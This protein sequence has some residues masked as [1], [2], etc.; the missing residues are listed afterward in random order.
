MADVAV[1]VIEDSKREKSDN[2]GEIFFSSFAQ[3]KISPLLCEEL[4][5]EGGIVSHLRAGS[6]NEENLHKA[7][8][9]SAT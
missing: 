8:C 5:S 9:G 2:L 3:R 1:G 4:K 6:E 7:S